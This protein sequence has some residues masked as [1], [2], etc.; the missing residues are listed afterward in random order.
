MSKMARNKGKRGE[1]AVIDW[2]QPILDEVCKKIGSKQVLLQ[3]N[4]VQSD[5]GGTDIVGLDWLAAE[6]KNCESQGKANLAS[7][8]DQCDQQ[9]RDWSTSRQKMTP[10][11]FY[12]RNHQPIRVRMMGWCGGHDTDVGLPCLID[13]SQEA[14]EAY[15]RVRAGVE[16]AKYCDD[17]SLSE[18]CARGGSPCG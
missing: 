9:A 15:F 1:R 18:H 16:L 13:I 6:V 14:F 12:M 17:P 3:R 11:L 4:T 2:L 5:K 10:V 8:W 7:W